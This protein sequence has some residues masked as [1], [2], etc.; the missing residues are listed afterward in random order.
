MA[1]RVSCSG[2]AT[3]GTSRSTR[4]RVPCSPP[5][6]SSF[7]SFLLNKSIQRGVCI[8]SSFYSGSLLPRRSL[9]SRCK[10]ASSIS[11]APSQFSS[12]K[13][14]AGSVTASGRISRGLRSS[15]QSRWLSE[16]PEGRNEGSRDNASDQTDN[17]VSAVPL[18]RMEGEK[19]LPH[20]TIKYQ[21]S[22]DDE[23]DQLR[24]P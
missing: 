10:S 6:W 12:R 15:V 19:P 22:V 8:A 13:A 16:K 5:S 11:G 14:L 18:S 2:V 21:E 23:V 3:L 1:I 20:L 24:R 7:Q 17:E 9:D 4:R